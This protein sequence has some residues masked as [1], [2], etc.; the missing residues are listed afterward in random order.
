MTLQSTGTRLLLDPNKF[1][2]SPEEYN[3][4]RVVYQQ[5]QCGINLPHLYSLINRNRNT[6][7]K[8]NNADYM[9]LYRFVTENKRIF[10][11]RRY[12]NNL[13]IYPRHPGR[14]PVDLNEAKQNS[15]RYHA[16]PSHLQKPQTSDT[17]ISELKWEAKRILLSNRMLDLE[18]TPGKALAAYFEQYL[19]DIDGR[20]LIFQNKAP[21]SGDPN[22]LALPYETRF[23]SK[24]KRD[25]LWA[26][27]FGTWEKASEQYEDGVFLTLTTDPK[28]FPNLWCSIKNM[29]EAWNRFMSFIQ[30]RTKRC[31]DCGH[32]YTVDPKRDATKWCKKCGSHRIKGHR[33]DYVKALEFTKSGLCHLHVV[34]FGIERL[35]SKSDISRFW[36]NTGQGMI[37][38]IYKIKQ[39]KGKW[40][41]ASHHE[42]PKKTKHKPMIY[43]K[44]EL[45]KLFYDNRCLAMY[46]ITRCK[47]YSWTGNLKPDKPIQDTALEEI[48][49]SGKWE[50][51]GSFY[52]HSLPDKFKGEDTLILGGPPPPVEHVRDLLEGGSPGGTFSQGS[53]ADK[54]ITWESGRE[55]S[56]LNWSR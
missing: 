34:L 12:D 32:I 47:F 13:W 23:N 45:S 52:L 33:P 20:V 7:P 35:A 10:I 3:I 37:T 8:E 42:R 21:K 11:I 39:R 50:Y 9:R 41:W 53:A 28:R 38:Y 46:W 19:I 17:V 4:F 22:Y 51:V 31:L 1:C 2:K 27:Y 40:F 26:T 6:A 18:G 48:N 24:P 14:G 25:K 43:M 5:G 16:S 55:R 54:L 49:K 15:N 44:K 29:G 30:K 56:D 36:S